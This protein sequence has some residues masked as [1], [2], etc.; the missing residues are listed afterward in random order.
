MT[1]Q[2]KK[3]KGQPYV[4]NRYSLP[5]GLAS[6]KRTPIYS[7]AEMQNKD[8]YSKETL[9]LMNFIKSRNQISTGN[10]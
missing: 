9:A 10:R 6:Y 1:I 5:N 2:K 7:E 4:I 8:K 3:I